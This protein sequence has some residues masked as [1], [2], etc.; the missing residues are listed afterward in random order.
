MNHALDEYV[1]A[2]VHTNGI[3]GFWSQL[4]RSIHGTFHQV[5]RKHL[6]AYVDEFVYRYNRRKLETP[7]FHDLSEKVG[8]VSPAYAAGQT[9]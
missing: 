1:R 7:L 6:Q 5:S 9:S 2:G 4:K 8:R 3:E